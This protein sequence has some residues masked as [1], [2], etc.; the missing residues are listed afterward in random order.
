MEPQT[1]VVYASNDHWTRTALHLALALARTRK[2][3]I[4]LFEMI[5][6]QHLAW[7]GTELGYQDHVMKNYAQLRGYEQIAQEYGV[8]LSTYF[9]QYYSSLSEAI[10]DSARQLDAAV[11][12]ATLPNTTLAVWRKYQLRRLK[13]QLMKQQCQLFT[14]E[15]PANTPDW[16]PSITA[17]VL[18]K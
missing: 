14:L 3:E 9:F 18:R 6:V 7:L 17:P 8:S 11:V 16:T 12:F 15:K 1:V 2:L 5:P 13:N 10:V 4:A